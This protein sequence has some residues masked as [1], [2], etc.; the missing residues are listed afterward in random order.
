MVASSK[1]R[2]MPVSQVWIQQLISY[3]V[4]QAVVYQ[5]CIKN[6]LGTMLKILM[7]LALGYVV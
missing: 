5:Y 7:Y 1:L 6:L 2:S 3:Q 4:V